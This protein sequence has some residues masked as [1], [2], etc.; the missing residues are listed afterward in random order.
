[1]KKTL[2]LVLTMVLLMNTLFVSA[3]A[4]TAAGTDT[5]ITPRWTNTAVVDTSFGVADDTA[6]VF[7]NYFAREEIFTHAVLK[8]TVQ[9]RF[10]LVFWRDID[11][12]T[13]TSNEYCTYF[14]HHTPVT[15]EGM[16]RAKFYLEFYGNTGAVDVVEHNIEYDYEK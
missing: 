3:G 10:L 9:K 5:G 1:M 6:E 13:Q 14:F 16:Y 15:E 4:T 8:V 12:W 11:V 2:L 7:V